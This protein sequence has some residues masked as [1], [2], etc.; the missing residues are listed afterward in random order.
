MNHRGYSPQHDS[1]HFVAGCF[2]FPVWISLVALKIVMESSYSFACEWA[3]IL[4]LLV[5]L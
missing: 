4:A 5:K 3:R 1:Q 2:S